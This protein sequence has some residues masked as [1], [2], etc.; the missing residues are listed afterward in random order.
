LP[1]GLGVGHF[2]F[3]PCWRWGGGPREGEGAGG[4][5]GGGGVE[6]FAR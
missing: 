5:G 4:G 3:S 6:L 2:L 1:G